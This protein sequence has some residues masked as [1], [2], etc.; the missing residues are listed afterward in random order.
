MHFFT[1][2]LLLQT[3]R[4][5]LSG[6]SS[7]VIGLHSLYHRGFENNIQEVNLFKQNNIPSLTAL[8][9]DELL[10]DSEQVILIPAFCCQSIPDK[11]Q[12]WR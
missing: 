10:E 8:H 3:G 1:R 4:W 5:T 2:K 11:P 6:Y 9:L 7:E 12:R